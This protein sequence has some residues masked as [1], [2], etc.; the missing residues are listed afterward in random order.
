[1]T[2]E[3]MD[4]IAGFYEGVQVIAYD[5]ALRAVAKRRGLSPADLVAITE[6]GSGSP[7]ASSRTGSEDS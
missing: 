5:R 6:D 7:P 1:M 3:F 4:L 2:T